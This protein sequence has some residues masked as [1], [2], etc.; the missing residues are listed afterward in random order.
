MLDDRFAA[1]TR[2][3]IEDERAYANEVGDRDNRGS[4]ADIQELS[5]RLQR[6]AMATV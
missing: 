4:A 1:F 5:P 3:I 6:L 2:C